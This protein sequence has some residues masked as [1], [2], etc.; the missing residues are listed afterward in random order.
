LQAIGE[1]AEPFGRNQ[2]GSSAMPFKRNP[3]NAENINSLAR[4]VAS[5]PRVAWD[6]AAHSLLERTL[7]DSANRREMFP[8]A[9]LAVDEIL[10]KATRLIRDLTIDEVA[11]ARNLNNHSLFVATERVLM[12]AVA[13][14]ADRQMMH[15]IIRGHSMKAQADIIAGHSNSLLALLSSDPQITFYLTSAQ[16]IALLDASQYI[17]DA[18]ERARDL[19]NLID[20]ELDK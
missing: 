16:I 3:I 20:V 1:W 9:F 11:I 13:A 18:P 2:V 4:F 15:E 19:A 14:G 7:D 8:A 12:A 6:N 10:K 17:G 5:L